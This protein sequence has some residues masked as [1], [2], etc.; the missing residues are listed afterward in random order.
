MR[1]RP[2]NKLNFLR[3]RL[4]IRITRGGRVL[5]AYRV[6]LRS[7]CSNDYMVF[8][9]VGSGYRGDITN[10]SKRKLNAC[11]FAYNSLEKALLGRASVRIRIHKKNNASTP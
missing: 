1:T 3:C 8:S 2:F 4:G 10:P 11:V 7:T 5:A 9:R 6:G